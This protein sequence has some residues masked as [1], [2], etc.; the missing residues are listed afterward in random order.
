ML[1]N[2]DRL[3]NQDIHITLAALRFMQANLPRL[4]EDIEAIATNDG[5]SPLPDTEKLDAL[6]ELFNFDLPTIPDATVR[7]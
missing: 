3:T 6:C 4:P 5:E 1:N 2:D 7:S